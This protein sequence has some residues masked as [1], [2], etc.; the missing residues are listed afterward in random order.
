MTQRRFASATSPA[1]AAQLRGPRSVAEVVRLRGFF[2]V[3]SKVWRLR[4]PVFAALVLA[5]LI[6]VAPAADSRETP[7]VR[8]VK[9]AKASV[10][11]IHS[12]K[13]APAGDPLFSPAGRKVNGMGTGIVV[14][15]T[16]LDP[17]TTYHFRVVAA[18]SGGTTEG[19]DQTFTTDQPPTVTM[20]PATGITTDGATLNGSVNAHG[21]E[22][23]IIFEY[24]TSPGFY[25]ESVPADQGTLSGSS[26]TDVHATLTGLVAGTT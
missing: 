6:A 11:N 13:T 24:G 8:A 7:L 21:L 15:H 14:D 2:L 19:T 5:W 1:E 3:S 22:T 12:E 4:L 23:T 26:S 17:G 25:D 16:G 20:N 10:V 18:N 9:R